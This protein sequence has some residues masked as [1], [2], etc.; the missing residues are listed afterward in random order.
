M[1]EVEAARALAALPPTAPGQV[2]TGDAIV[3]HDGGAAWSP[4][5]LPAL[6]RFFVERFGRPLPVSAVG[7]SVVHDRLGFDHRH[8]VDIAVHP[9]SPEGRA[10]LEHLRARS[11]PFLA[12]RAARPGVATGAHVHVGRP[13]VPAPGGRSPGV[14]RA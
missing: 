13:S 5:A 12:F 1:T 2:H 9:D 10:L 11:I 6:E 4:S 14:P 7:Q 8:A 3:R